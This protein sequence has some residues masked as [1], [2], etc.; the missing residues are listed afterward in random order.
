MSHRCERLHRVD[1]EPAE[2]RSQRRLRGEVRPEANILYCQDYTPL[3]MSAL[4]AAVEV[5]HALNDQLTP[6][7]A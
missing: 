3:E 4:H 2:R 7:T 5:V 6:R 1:C